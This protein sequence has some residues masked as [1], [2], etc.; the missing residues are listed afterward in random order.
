MTKD[1]DARRIN[2]V[3]DFR[4]IFARVL[5]RLKLPA[6]RRSVI[7]P[8]SKVEG[9]SQVVD[10]VFGRHSYCGYDCTFLNVDVGSF[11]SI[12]ESVFVGGS[13]HPMHFVST[14][15][16]FLSHRDSVKTKLARFDYLNL[17]RTRIGHDVWIGYGARMRAGETIGHGAVVAMGSVVTRDVPHYSVVG[18]NPAD[19]IRPRFDKNI[20]RKLLETSW[21]DLPDDEL[22]HWA[23]YFNDP[24]RF[25]DEWTRK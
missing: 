22:G 18:G 4:Y 20:A 3:S 25:L 10:T 15:P 13:G 21:W 14:S 24:E 17:P 23:P 12:S 7:H 2:P 9:G 1:Q 16:V 19:I 11:C 8:T 5:K 6:I